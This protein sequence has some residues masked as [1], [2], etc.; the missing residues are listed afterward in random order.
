MGGTTGIPVTPGIDLAAYAALE[1]RT[2]LDTWRA[3]LGYN[4]WHFWQ[5]ANGK[6]PLNDACLALVYEYAWQ[7]ADR[8]GRAD[9]RQALIDALAKMSERLGYTPDERHQVDTVAW[10]ERLRAMRYLPLRTSRAFVQALGSEVIELVQAGVAV[11]YH[12]DD[13][14]GLKERFSLTVAVPAGLPASELA[15]AFSSSD[16]LTGTPMDWRVQPVSVSVA[17]TAA[18]LTGPAWLLVRPIQYEGAD[19][20]DIDPDTAANFAATLDVYRVRT[21]AGTSEATAPVVLNWRDGSV[22]AVTARISDSRRGEIELDLYGAGTEA[23]LCTGEPVNV[24]LRYRAGHGLDADH[25]RAVCRLAAAELA[26][27]I[28]ACETASRQLHHWQF[29]LSHTGQGGMG[30]EQYGTTAEVLNCPFGTRRGQVEA[31]KFVQRHAVL[32][33]LSR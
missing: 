11:S 30:G 20:A 12:D 3:V 5:L 19:V 10:P 27:P 25:L 4:P 15:A 22:R 14:D 31:W 26:R 17:G 13:G 24:T 2:L 21:V 18:T 8:A 7:N 6:V 23:A 28:C 1:G 32:G 29:D 33:G 9:V 16:R